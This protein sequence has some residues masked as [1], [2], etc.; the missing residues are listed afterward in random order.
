MHLNHLRL[1]KPVFQAH[2]FYQHIF[3]QENDNKKPCYHGSSKVIYRTYGLYISGW[4]I[5]IRFISGT[6]GL[7][8]SGLY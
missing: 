6:Y 3:P 5:Y 2:V 1:I 4:F 7:Y 8:I